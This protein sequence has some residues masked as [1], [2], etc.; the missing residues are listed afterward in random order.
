MSNATTTTTTTTN[1]RG[2]RAERSR[3]FTTDHHYIAGEARSTLVRSI[4]AAASKGEAYRYTVSAEAAA[5][6]ETLVAQGVERAD[7]TREV[8]SL[9]YGKRGHRDDRIT[10]RI[11]SRL[12]MGHPERIAGAAAFA[13]GELDEAEW[14]AIRE[15]F[16]GCFAVRGLDDETID[17]ALTEKGR[18]EYDLRDAVSG[19]VIG[20]AR[21]NRYGPGR[22]IRKA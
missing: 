4:L 21:G 9:V 1:N 12:I 6:V 15:R 19:D 18:C 16:V 2:A 13:A 17:I 22:E 10:N 11:A 8:T 5:M 3:S 14:D 7:A 20:F